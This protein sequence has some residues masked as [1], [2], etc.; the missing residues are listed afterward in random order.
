MK[1]LLTALMCLALVP[2]ALA[3]GNQVSPSEEQAIKEL[4]ARYH[5]A[6][7]LEDAVAIGALFTADAD[8]LVS[9]GEWRHGRDEL[10][11]GMMRSTQQ[12]PGKRTIT[13]DA[14]R[15]IQPGIALADARYVI[16]DTT[17]DRRMWSTFLVVQSDQGWRIAALRNMLPAK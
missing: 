16:E 7:D 8:Q 5:A 10:V 14:I 11:A 13:V 3:Q 12:R 9:T 2:V 1:T 17:G 4:V 6:R 15:Q